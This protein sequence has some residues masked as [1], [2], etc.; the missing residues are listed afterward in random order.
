MEFGYAIVE[1]DKEGFD[2]FFFNGID[3]QTLVSNRVWAR[4]KDAN[5]ALVKI[6]EDISEDLALGLKTV[7]ERRHLLFWKYVTIERIPMKP[8]V[9]RQHEVLLNS[10]RVKRIR[11]A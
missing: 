3:E 10:L 1:K 6:K 4:E 8:D 11:I 9:Y 5:E 2:R 7:V